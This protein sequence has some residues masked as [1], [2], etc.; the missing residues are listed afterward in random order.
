VFLIPENKFKF[1]ATLTVREASCNKL[2]PR[3]VY[4]F[5]PDQVP[6]GLFDRQLSHIDLDNGIEESCFC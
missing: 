6:D 5:H 3:F 2:K 4:G 1:V